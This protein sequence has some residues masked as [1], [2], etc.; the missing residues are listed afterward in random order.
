MLDE[1][2]SSLKQKKNDYILLS[3][4]VRLSEWIYTL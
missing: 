3:C 4:Q 1:K 2:K